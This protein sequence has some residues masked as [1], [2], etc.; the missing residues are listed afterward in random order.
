MQLM[1]WLRPF[2]NRRYDKVS[3]H[4]SLVDPMFARFRPTI[5]RMI[6]DTRFSLFSSEQN[7]FSYILPLPILSPVSQ[8]DVSGPKLGH[9]KGPQRQRAHCTT[10][11]KRRCEPLLLLGRACLMFDVWFHAR[12]SWWHAPDYACAVYL[13][14][15]SSAQTTQEAR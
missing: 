14:G 13:P 11:W 6:W 8:T 10:L 9:H 15:S 5:W 7:E 12:M 1:N 3:S 4:I 2:V